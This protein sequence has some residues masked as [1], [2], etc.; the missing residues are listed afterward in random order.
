MSDWLSEWAAR[1]AEW[2]ERARRF[3]AHLE[4]CPDPAATPCGCGFW[5]PEAAR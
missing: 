5:Q 2:N 1:Q 4:S 3:L